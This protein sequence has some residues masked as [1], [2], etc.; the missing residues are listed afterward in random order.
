MGSMCQVTCTRCGIDRTESTGVGM[1]G[2][3]REL[4]A[5]VT[6]ARLVIVEFTGFGE[7]RDLRC[8]D[9]AQAVRPVEHDDP[10]PTC[11]EPLMVVGIALFWD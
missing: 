10:C 6:C 2:L 3:G 11:G 8:P 1:L 5:C 9:C 7:D 4:C